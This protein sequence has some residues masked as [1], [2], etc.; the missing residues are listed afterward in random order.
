MLAVESYVK[1]FPLSLSSS[2][3]NLRFAVMA[4]LQMLRE[5]IYLGRT[6]SL[7]PLLLGR[8]PVFEASQPKQHETIVICELVVVETSETFITRHCFQNVRL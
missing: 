1:Q 8:L 2:L 5:A 3:Q 4:L 6:L 7:Q